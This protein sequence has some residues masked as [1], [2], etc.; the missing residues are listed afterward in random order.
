A[1]RVMDCGDAGHILVSRAVAEV[2]GETSRWRSVLHDIGEIEV[3]HGAHV[4]LHNLYGEGF[5]ND[6]VPQKVLQQQ[7]Q[8]SSLR[9]ANARRKQRRVSLAI[10]LAGVV[11]TVIAASTFYTHRAHALTDKDTV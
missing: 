10:I 2:I 8:V 7:A 3:K 11:V 5:G 4:H 9:T 1:Q 6:E